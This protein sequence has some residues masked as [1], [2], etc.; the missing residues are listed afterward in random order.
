MPALKKSSPELIETFLGAL[1]QDERVERRQMFGFP[2]VFVG[3]NMFAGLFEE[4]MVVRLS[5]RDRETL[6]AI[7]GA[8]VFEPMKGRPMKEYTVVPTAMHA[9]AAEL[10]SW[11][12]GALDYGAAL[13]AKTAKKAT[14]KKAGAKPAKKAAKRAKGR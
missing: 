4:H 10:R 12:S 9:K 2:A 8:C 14:A 13:P 11:L 3:G 6:R 5:E 7:P 1:P